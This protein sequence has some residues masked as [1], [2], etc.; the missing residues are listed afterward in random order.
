MKPDWTLPPTRSAGDVL[1]NIVK[2]GLSL[3]AG[4]L[5]DL[6]AFVVRAP[7]ERRME[8]WL[9]RCEMR[10]RHLADRDTQIIASLPDRAEFVSLF[11]SATQAAI[12]THHDSKLNML[13]LAVTHSAE[14]IDVDADLQL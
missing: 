9:E 11:I 14:G 7:F 13:A 8:N 1:H 10:F 6:F 3:K 4:P 2:V 12:R 5:G